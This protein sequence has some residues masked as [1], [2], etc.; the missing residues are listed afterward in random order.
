MLNDELQNQYKIFYLIRNR[1][2]FHE[3]SRPFSTKALIIIKGIPKI[4]ARFHKGN[5]LTSLRTSI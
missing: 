3:S 4:A 2:K 1:I 5:P